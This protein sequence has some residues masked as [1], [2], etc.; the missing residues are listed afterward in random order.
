MA[1]RHRE[2]IEFETGR[3]AASLDAA[4]VRDRLADEFDVQTSRAR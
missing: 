3:E 2:A 1:D 4:E